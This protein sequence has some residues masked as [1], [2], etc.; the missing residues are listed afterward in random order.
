MI[1]SSLRFRFAGRGFDDSFR[2]SQYFSPIRIITGKGKVIFKT[3]KEASDDGKLS[4]KC[5]I[6]DTKKDSNG[7]GGGSGT[8]AD[9][10]L[11]P[12]FSALLSFYLFKTGFYC[13]VQP[14]RNGY[15]IKFNLHKDNPPLSRPEA[16]CGPG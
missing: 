12:L 16:L 15:F 9:P 14:F 10:E 1:D 3:G 13:F 5:R 11:F 4:G 8:A 6:T 2:G 7:E